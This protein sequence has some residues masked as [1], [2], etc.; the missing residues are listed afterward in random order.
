MPDLPASLALT[1]IANGAQILSADHR[2]NY[3]AIQTA[4]N[5]NITALSGGTAGQFLR[6]TDSD[7]IAWAGNYTDYSS[8]LAWTSTGVAPVLG[9]ATIVARYL[10]IGKFVHYVGQVTFGGTSTFGTGAYFFSL[11]VNR[12]AGST[13]RLNGTVNGVDTSASATVLCQADTTGS[14]STFS[15]VYGATYLGTATN[16]GTGSPWTWANTDVITWNMLYE[17]A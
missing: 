2:N 11:P 8:F 13:S 15:M 5:A 1:T 6:A 16:I 10:Q 7:T 9:N 4:V 17:A 14:V 12:A 3:T